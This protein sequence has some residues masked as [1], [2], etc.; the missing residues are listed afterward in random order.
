[1]ISLLDF[2]KVFFKGSLLKLTLKMNLSIKWIT[3]NKIVILIAMMISICFRTLLMLKGLN[4][5]YNRNKVGLVQDISSLA[6]NKTFNYKRISKKRC[7]IWRFNN[8]K[9]KKIFEKFNKNKLKMIRKN[10][11]LNISTKLP[12]IFLTLVLKLLMFKPS[13]N[14]SEMIALLIT[15]IRQTLTNFLLH[16]KKQ[17]AS[18]KK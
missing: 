15:N 17:T 18:R 16:G 2:F 10:K 13:K 4:Q 7:K 1:M 14:H 5:M 6:N 9:I 3:F 12:I 8:R 11:R